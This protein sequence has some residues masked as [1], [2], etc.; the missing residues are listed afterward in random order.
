MITREN[1]RRT[2]RTVEWLLRVCSRPCGRAP[3]ILSNFLLEF[4][5]KITPERLILALITVT[6]SNKAKQRYKRKSYR[7]LKRSGKLSETSECA[8]RCT[9]VAERPKHNHLASAFQAH[10]QVDDGNQP[11][12]LRTNKINCRHVLLQFFVKTPVKHS[13]P[14]Q[15]RIE[16][17]EDTQSNLFCDLVVDFHL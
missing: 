8:Q 11:V 14:Q 17:M 5:E 6:S 3:P 13:S 16:E 7:D 4:V 15:L 12:G 9:T 2:R 1:D 10:Y